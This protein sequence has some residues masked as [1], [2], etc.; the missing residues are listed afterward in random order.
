MTKKKILTIV[1]IVLTAMPVAVRADEG[2]WIPMLL[3]RNEAA[4]QKAGMHISAQDIY[5]INNASLKKAA[6]DHI[7]SQLR[8]GGFVR[9]KSFGS[10]K[11]LSVKDDILTV[12]FGEKGE[13]KLALSLSLQNNLL[14]V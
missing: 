11:I 12:D 8:A 1:A 5:D 6:S 2:M 4:M 3:G 9:H 13:R 7:L 14:S 10:G